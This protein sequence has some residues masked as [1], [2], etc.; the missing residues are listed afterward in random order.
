MPRNRGLSDPNSDNVKLD[1]AAQRSIERLWAAIR[2]PK[3]SLTFHDLGTTLI[4]MPVRDGDGSFVHKPDRDSINKNGTAPRHDL[5]TIINTL[6]DDGTGS[7]GT[8]TVAHRN[9]PG[10]KDPASPTS[11]VDPI[12]DHPGGPTPGGSGPKPTNPA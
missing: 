2:G 9:L 3:S 5:S 1:P 6:G 7:S 8:G 12:K 4:S 11:G 10:V